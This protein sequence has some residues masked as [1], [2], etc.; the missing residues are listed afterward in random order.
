MLP[1]DQRRRWRGQ[2]EIAL[3]VT[4]VGAGLVRCPRTCGT[5]SPSSAAV[6]PGAGRIPTDEN[7]VPQWAVGRRGGSAAVLAPSQTTGRVEN[8]RLRP[9]ADACPAHQDGQAAVPGSR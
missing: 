9:L 2:T 5:D 6:A 3:A 7:R 8:S 1:T 4:T